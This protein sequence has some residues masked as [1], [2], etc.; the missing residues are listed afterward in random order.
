MNPKS[1]VNRLLLWKQYGKILN[2]ISS[3]L[4]L[5]RFFC[6]HLPSTDKLQLHGQHSF[7]SLYQLSGMQDTHHPASKYLTIKCWTIQSQTHD[8]DCKQEIRTCCSLSNC[9]ADREDEEEPCIGWLLGVYG[10]LPKSAVS[11]IIASSSSFGDK[12]PNYKYICDKFD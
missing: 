11:S 6:W 3:T 1:I 5:A 12:L 9:L 8:G 7:L 4:P 2:I 10:D